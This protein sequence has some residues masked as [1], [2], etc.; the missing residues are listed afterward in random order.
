MS[1]F[2]TLTYVRLHD[3]EICQTLCQT[4]DFMI[5]LTSKVFFIDRASRE[6]IKN[7]KI[8]RIYDREGKEV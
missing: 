8:K 3:S 7:Q 6:R 4:Y 2:M 1:D 5:D